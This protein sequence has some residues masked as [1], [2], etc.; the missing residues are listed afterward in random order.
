MTEPVEIFVQVLAR[1][2]TNLVQSIRAL[3]LYLYYE[4]T[5]QA[6]DENLFRAYDFFN[7]KDHILSEAIIFSLL[8]SRLAIEKLK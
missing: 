3:G 5:L 6:T 7:R 4:C 2:L 1:W 8:L